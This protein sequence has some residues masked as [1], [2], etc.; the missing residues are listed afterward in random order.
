MKTKEWLI[1]HLGDGDILEAAVLRELLDSYI[2]KSE[3]G[4]VGAGD[5]RVVS[6][7][8]VNRAIAAACES[9]VQTVRGMVANILAEMLPSI[10]AN[11]VTSSGLATALADM[12]TKTWVNDQ[13]SG[14]ATNSAVEN[15]ISQHDDSMR[16]EIGTRLL[17]YALIADLSTHI[18]L[19]DYAQKT[20]LATLIGVS[21]FALKTELPDLTSL[22]TK[23]ELT[24]YQTLVN[25][26]LLA[27]ASQ[28]DV[29]TAKNEA[30]SAAQ[31]YTDT[32]VAGVESQCLTRNQ[33]DNLYALKTP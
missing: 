7:D 1:S 32:E 15:A 29:Q 25:T 9:V 24:N 12:A 13:I 2:H 30:V 6:G 23:T 17:P 4:G 33:A 22:A 26:S 3:F 28:A 14:L 20:E 27:K 31:A 10:L 21:N 11:Y 18:G 19:S 5:E 16:T 8:S